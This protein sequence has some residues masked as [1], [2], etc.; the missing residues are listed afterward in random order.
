[1]HYYLPVKRNRGMDQ[2]VSVSEEN[3]YINY[4]DVYYGP[5]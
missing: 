3:C 1:M 5:L 2:I 4:Y